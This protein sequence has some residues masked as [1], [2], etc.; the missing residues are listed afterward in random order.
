V[1]KQLRAIPVQQENEAEEAEAP[2]PARQA[3]G[4]GNP[5]KA[6]P[7]V[8]PLAIADDKQLLKRCDVGPGSRLGWMC[9]YGLI[10]TSR[11]RAAPQHTGLSHKEQSKCFAV[12]RQA[13][14]RGNP[15]GVLCLLCSKAG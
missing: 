9:T 7:H 1:L 12:I 5:S 4:R 13:I 3:I 8:H 2:V 15:S 6:T 11:V 14:G 10:G